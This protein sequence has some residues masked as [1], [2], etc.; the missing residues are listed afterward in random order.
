MRLLRGLD[1]ERAHLLAVKA[2]RLAGPFLH[3]RADDPILATTLFGRALPNPI[4]LAAGFD[5][6]A[7]C[8]DALLG[9]GFGWVEIGSVTPRPQP[10]NPTPRVFRLDEDAAVINR[11]GFNS[12]GIDAVARRLASRARRGVVGVNLGRNKE[13]EDAAA[14]YEAGA[15]ALGPHADYLVVNVSSPNS[16]GLRE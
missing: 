11:Y 14:D 4:G 13:T 1:P 3:A 8:P 12:H 2:L 6:H 15:R 10:G 7:E 16:P 9:L 5:K